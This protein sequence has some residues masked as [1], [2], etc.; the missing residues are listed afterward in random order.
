[1]AR[2]YAASAVVWSRSGELVVYDG[3]ADRVL[4]TRETAGPPFDAATAAAIALSV[5]TLLLHATGMPEAAS[6]ATAGASLE[7]T[8]NRAE[9]PAR[10]DD[11]RDVSEPVPDV[12]AADTR[13]PSTAAGPRMPWEL[14]L[15][16]AGGFRSAMHDVAPEARFGVFTEL[17]PAASAF[18]VGLGFGAGSGFRMPGPD[19]NARVIEPSLGLSALLRAHIS[20]AWIASASLGPALLFALLRGELATDDTKLEVTRVTP[21]VQAA[22]RLE[23]RAL[24]PLIIGIWGQAGLSLV[25]QRYWVGE[26]LALESRSLTLAAGVAG[27]VP[28]RW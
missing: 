2:Q 15:L 1:M 24:D 18:G 5:K 23:W 21:Q 12:A 17:W 14:A 28:F 25:V 8:D 4:G 9:S 11:P 22:L 16:A 27:G 19:L 26:Q 3:D 13:E 10:S 6:K 20:S 7:E